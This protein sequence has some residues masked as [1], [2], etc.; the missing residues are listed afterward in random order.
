LERVKDEVEAVAK[1]TADSGV[2]DHGVLDCGRLE[3]SL[4]VLEE[5]ADAHH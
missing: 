2:R 1:L 3:R 4:E 5:L